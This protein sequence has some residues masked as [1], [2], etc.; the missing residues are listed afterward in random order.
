M[1]RASNMRTRLL[2]LPG[3]V[4]ARRRRSALRSVLTT[5]TLFR[6]FSCPYRPF[7]PA[8]SSGRRSY[9]PGLAP[10]TFAARYSVVC[11]QHIGFPVVPRTNTGTARAPQRLLPSERRTYARAD[12]SNLIDTCTA[13][14]AS[15]DHREI[16]HTVTNP[17]PCIAV[18]RR[19]HP[20]PCARHTLDDAKECSGAYGEVAARPD[21]NCADDLVSQIS[22]G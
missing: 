20:M 7:A 4:P 1:P 19:S 22:S 17:S 14:Q 15:R 12:I 13:V 5:P 8:H 6:P 11:T 2:R 9:R 10:G 18:S 21:E 3:R 16:A